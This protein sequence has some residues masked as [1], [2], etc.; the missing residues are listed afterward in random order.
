MLARTL[1]S[2]AGTA[3]PFVRLPR[4]RA[5]WLGLVYAGLMLASTPGCSGIAVHHA[6]AR[7]PFPGWHWTALRGSGDLSPRT[8]Q[9]LRQLD[10]EQAY[11]RKPAEAIARL[12]DEA[13]HDP[14][15]DLLFALAEIHF[16]G[17]RQAERQDPS[18]ASASYYLCAGYAYH[19]LF[20][21]SAPPIEASKSNVPH[22]KVFDPRFRLACDL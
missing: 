10:L 4:V 15:P 12:H 9:T 22:G 6:G 19:Y 17:G 3:M 5:A 11:R 18:S 1:R 13:C 16:V 8:W 21:G 20:H 14:Q 2:K 7:D